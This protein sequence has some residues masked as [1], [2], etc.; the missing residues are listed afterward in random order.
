[1][2]MVLIGIVAAVVLPHFASRDVYDVSGF[3]EDLRAVLRF[4]Q[5]S[6][7]AQH[8]NVYVNLDAAGRKLTACYDAAY[9][10]AA[11][12]AD[13]SGGAPLSLVAPATVA[14]TTTAGQLGF[15]WLGSPGGTGATISVSPSAGGAAVNIVVDA[16]SGYVQ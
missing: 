7:I 10:C 12:L 4:G 16:D 15:N 2:T 3:A 11:P 14:F 9:P 5:K 13:P 6:A 8:R 1:M